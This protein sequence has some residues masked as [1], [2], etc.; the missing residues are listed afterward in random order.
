M[1]AAALEGFRAEEHEVVTEDGYILVN[2][3]LPS[4]RNS[5]TVNKHPIFILPGLSATSDVFILMDGN[6]SIPYFLA[7]NGYDV[8]LVNPRGTKHSN[9]HLKYDSHKNVEYW[10]FR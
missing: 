10:K 8:W 5:T 4:P 2:H 1:E 6:H 3:R 9:R 7:N